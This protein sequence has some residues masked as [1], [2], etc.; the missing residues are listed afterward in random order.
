[1]TPTALDGVRILDL[2]HHIAGPYCTKL[3]VDYGGNAGTRISDGQT[4]AR[5]AAV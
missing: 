1:M 2:T 5:R 4:Q 3:L